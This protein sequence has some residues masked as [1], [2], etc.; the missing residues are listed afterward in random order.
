M[1]ALKPSRGRAWRCR[2]RS[3]PGSRC[4]S[5]QAKRPMRAE[6]RLLSSARR[7]NARGAAGAWSAHDPSPSGQASGARTSAWTQSRCHCRRWTFDQPKGEKVLV[8]P[9]R[10]EQPESITCFGFGAAQ[11]ASLRPAGD[12]A[13]RADEPLCVDGPHELGEFGFVGPRSQGQRHDGA[14]SF[15][16]AHRPPPRMPCG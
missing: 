10:A 16:D 6:P 9:R 4:R 15:E 11:P 12:G 3:R 1:S 2:G 13:G 8:G 5:P 14:A 7:R